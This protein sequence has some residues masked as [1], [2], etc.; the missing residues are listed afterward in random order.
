MIETH[1]AQLDHQRLLLKGNV[2]RM[3]TEIVEAAA[4]ADR[5]ENEFSQAEH[6]LRMVNQ[7]VGPAREALVKIH[8]DLLAAERELDREKSTQRGLELLQARIDAWVARARESIVETPVV[9]EEEALSAAFLDKLRAFVIALGCA[10]VTA[11]DG[12]AIT[13]DRHYIPALHDRWLRSYGSASDRA[14]LIVAYLL[15]LASV[16]RH[17]MG[18]VA[19]DEPLQQNPDAHHKRLFLDFLQKES[20]KISQQ[21]IIFT[22]LDDGE[23]AGLRKAGVAVQTIDERFLEAWKPSEFTPTVD[24][25]SPD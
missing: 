14:R 24:K 3:R 10:G 20:A 17:H 7:T 22:F 12:P 5:L 11:A 23:V 9:Q 25:P 21:I 2:E 13:L 4:R 8:S 15:S 1:V 16:G 6:A 18:F 19:L